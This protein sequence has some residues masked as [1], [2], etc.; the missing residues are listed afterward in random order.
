[1]IE[2]SSITSSPCGMISRQRA[3]TASTR[4]RASE[5]YSSSPRLTVEVFNLGLARV[6]REHLAN[7]GLGG[8]EALA[9]L[10]QALPALLE[11]LQRR[12]QV[13]DSAG[14]PRARAESLR[15]PRSRG[16]G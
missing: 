13:E 9:R 8:R 11:Q 5:R 4:A 6:G 12:V 3:S 10:A 1:M 14:W 16:C 15:R 7:P 2:T